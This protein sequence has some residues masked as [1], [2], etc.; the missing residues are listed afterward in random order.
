M[1]HE[2]TYTFQIYKNQNKQF[3]IEFNSHGVI[4]A[5]DEGT[6]AYQ[7]LRLDDK[8]IAMNGIRCKTYHD[9]LLLAKFSTNSA[10]FSIY[11]DLSV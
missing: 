1:E 11:R 4:G 8:I 9:I 2:I 6:H 7:V 3:G 10:I 5:L